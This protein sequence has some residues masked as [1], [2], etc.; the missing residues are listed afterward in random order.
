MSR[1]FDLILKGGEVVNHDGRGVADIGVTGGKTVEI[2]D[3][4][5]A[6]A[7]ETTRARRRSSASANARSRSAG[8]RPKRAARST[9]SGPRATPQTR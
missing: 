9:P 6:S 2:G 5:Q 7:A 8:T 4:S 1:T 3:L